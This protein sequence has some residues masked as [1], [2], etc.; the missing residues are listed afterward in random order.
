MK[1]AFSLLELII[2]IVLISILIVF[3]VQKS[4]DSIN[5]TNKTKIK[6]EITLI[7]NAITKQKTSN[8]LLNKSQI[9]SLDN[10]NLEEENS[11]LFKTI[12]DFPLISTTSSKKELAKWI[13]S[14]KN[15]YKIFIDDTKSLEFK[16]ENNSF[17]CKSSVSLCK[18]FE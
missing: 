6:S 11:L 12:L 1:K 10:A 4:D 7:R 2:V 13:K 16:F 5:F 14:S 15:E 17:I 3:V 8:I 18:E 9:N